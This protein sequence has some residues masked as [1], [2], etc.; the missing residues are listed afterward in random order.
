MAQIHI[1]MTPLFRNNGTIS[2]EDFAHNQT[3]AHTTPEADPRQIKVSA[4]NLMKQQ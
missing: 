2:P 3:E 4:W 1:F